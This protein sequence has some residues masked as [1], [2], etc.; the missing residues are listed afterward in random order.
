METFS[1]RPETIQSLIEISG[2]IFYNSLFKVYF[3]KLGTQVQR[4]INKK[5][6]FP[7]KNCLTYDSLCAK[8]VGAHWHS[9]KIFLP[10]Q[11]TFFFLQG[12]SNLKTCFLFTFYLEGEREVFFLR[13]FFIFYFLWWISENKPAERYR[14]RTNFKTWYE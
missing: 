9:D 8:N 14:T 13:K 1:P 2:D 12:R 6:A 5:R 10:W 11:Y 3:T 4:Q 7:G